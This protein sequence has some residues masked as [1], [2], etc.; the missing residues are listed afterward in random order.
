MTNIKNKLYAVALFGLSFVLTMIEK[1]ATALI[2]TSF[3]SV[4]MFFAKES[5][6][7]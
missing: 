5:W 6:I 3:I 4:P 7:D 1:D 2:L